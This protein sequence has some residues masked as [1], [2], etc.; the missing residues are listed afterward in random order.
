MN[1]AGRKEA[2]QRAQ[3]LF[4]HRPVY[5][6]TETTGTGPH[7]EIIEIA[8]VDHEGSLLF[9]S[10]VRPRGAIEPDAQRVH[11]ISQEM[12]KG[13]P[14]WGDI[15]AQVEAA[16][17]GRMI[18]VYNVDFD[19]RLMK[20]THTRNWLRWQ[21]DDRAFF[22]VMKLYARFYGEWDPRRGSYRF[23][24]LEKAGQ[25]AGIPLPNSHR[26]QD[27]ALLTRALLE[28]MANWKG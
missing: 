1:T 7:A 13:A 9:Q 28:Y 16:L 5:L 23:Q 25:Q 26:A 19:L 18:G 11:H 22:C 20:Q 4:Q 6:D 17:A 3:E 12:V 27:D 15:W 21:M 14:T 2:V 24:S 8:I 10:L